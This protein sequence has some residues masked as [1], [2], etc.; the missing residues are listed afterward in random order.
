MNMCPLCEAGVP[1]KRDPPLL[2]LVNPATSL[3]TGGYLKLSPETYRWLK[4]VASDQVRSER[5]K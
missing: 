1:I 3:P 5:R 4:S 2:K